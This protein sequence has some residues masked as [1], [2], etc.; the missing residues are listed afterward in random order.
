MQHCLGHIQGGVQDCPVVDT[1]VCREARQAQMSQG[2][3]VQGLCL[4]WLSSTA[5][6]VSKED[7]C[8]L[9]LLNTTHLS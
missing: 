4:P 2:E 1:S 5:Q 6:G 3:R 7:H 8:C 9:T